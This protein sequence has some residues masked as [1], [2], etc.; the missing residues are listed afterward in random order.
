[1]HT[2][3]D[4]MTQL[5]H[6]LVEDLKIQLKA[7]EEIHAQLLQ[8]IEESTY[9]RLVATGLEKELQEA[10]RDVAELKTRMK[11]WLALRAIPA[12]N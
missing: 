2:E 7:R 5:T 12:Q 10:K 6:R 8:S 4:P 9:W 11:S 1:M 3:Q